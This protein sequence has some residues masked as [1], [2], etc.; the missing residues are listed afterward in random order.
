[1]SN[2]RLRG[3]GDR[4]RRMRERAVLETI[5]EH[6]A[7]DTRSDRCGDGEPLPNADRAMRRERRL[8]LTH[9]NLRHHIADEGIDA[10][11]RNE[12]FAADRAEEEVRIDAHR[13]VEAGIAV[14]EMLEQ[15]WFAGSGLQ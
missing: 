5:G 7:G 11:G 9:A 3:D 10:A 6:R 8:R 1:M 15:L 12:L 2:R 4:T 14:T 13:E